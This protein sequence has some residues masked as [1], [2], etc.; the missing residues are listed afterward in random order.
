MANQKY[1][2]EGTVAEITVGNGGK[3]KF[4]ITG[5]EGYSLKQKDKKY[6]VLFPL[7]KNKAEENGNSTNTKTGLI[8]EQDKAFEMNAKKNVYLQ[9][10]Q[11]AAN[12]KRIRLEIFDTITDGNLNSDPVRLKTYSI[13]LLME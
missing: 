13:T 8:F 3:I 11:A 5:S 9:I 10:L 1:I 2:I 12:G 4:K 6:N 7:Q